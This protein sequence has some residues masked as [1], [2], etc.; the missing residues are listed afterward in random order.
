MHNQGEKINGRYVDD[1]FLIHPDKQY[2][3]QD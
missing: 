3:I 2:L 1:I